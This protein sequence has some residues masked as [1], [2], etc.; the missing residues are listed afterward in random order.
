MIDWNQ[1]SPQ[2]F[3]KLCC[4]ILS[5]N[6]FSNIRWYG[7]GGGDKGRDILATRI[8]EPLPNTQESKK[9]VVQ[10]KRYTTCS[11]SKKEIDEIFTDAK[12]HDPDYLLI[13]T[14][15]TLT[16]NTKDWLESVKGKHGFIPYVWEQIDLEREVSKHGGQLS[17]HFSFVPSRGKSVNFYHMVPSGTT[18]YCNEVEEVGFHILNRYDQKTEIQMIKEFI[19]FIR[20]N[21]II[22]EDG[23]EAEDDSV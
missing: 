19:Q 2:E 14:C 18:Y 4:E 12:E 23:S 21:E 10:C 13:V 8:E 15:S 3:E 20:E 6:G 1:V 22:V 16:S 9:W 17:Q 5:L 11:L 7:K